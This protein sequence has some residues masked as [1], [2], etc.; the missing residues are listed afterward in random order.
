MFNNKIELP[1]DKQYLNKIIATGM[2]K[3]E[4]KWIYYDLNKIV[5]LF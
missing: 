1:G 4:L 2:V 3:K 5:E